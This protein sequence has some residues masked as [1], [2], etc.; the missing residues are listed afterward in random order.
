MAGGTTMVKL[1]TNDIEFITMATGNT[2]D[3]GDIQCRW[4]EMVVI[5]ITPE[6][7]YMGG[8]AC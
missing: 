5:Q 3:F 2:I 7:L 1:W 8:T 4:E 6:E